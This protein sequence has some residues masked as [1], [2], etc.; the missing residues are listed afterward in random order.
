MGQSSSRKL[1]HHGFFLAFLCEIHAHMLLAFRRRMFGTHT[2]WRIAGL[3]STSA[4]GPCDG[5]RKGD[6]VQ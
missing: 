4:A 6:V 1:S 5:K 2:T 3:S